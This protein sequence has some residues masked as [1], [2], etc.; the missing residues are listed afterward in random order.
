MLIDEAAELAEVILG[1]DDEIRRQRADLDYL[2]RL[3]TAESRRLDGHAGP[4][5]PAMIS[6]AITPADPVLHGVGR[7]LAVIDWRGAYAQLCA[8]APAA[9]PE[10]EAEEE[11]NA[12]P[13][14]R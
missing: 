3:I 13:V 6:R 10:G 5:I 1:A 14:L 7:D 2:A 9:V 8:T 12:P 4:A 11:L